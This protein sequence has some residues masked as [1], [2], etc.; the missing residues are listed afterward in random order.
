M[1]EVYLPSLDY[2]LAM[3][4]VAGRR[5]DMRDARALIQYLNIS[6][7]QEVIDVLQKYMPQQYL[8]VKLQYIIEDLLA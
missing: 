5:Q 2:L 3:K 7:S 4:I 6:H 8:T 1:T